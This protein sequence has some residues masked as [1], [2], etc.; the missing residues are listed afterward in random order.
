MIP[1]IIFFG[2]PNFAV[3]LLD[4]INKRQYLIDAVVT[5]SDKKSG[6]GRKLK[7]SA[8]KDYCVIKNITL[9]QPENL[10]EES[11]VSKIKKHNSDMFVVVAYRML[12]KVI[13]S[14]PRLGTFNLHA[15]LLPNY[16][17]AAPINWVIINQERIT[18][19]TTFLIDESID[20]GKILLKSE[21]RMNTNETY[22]TLH[23][24]LLK[25]AKPLIINTIN[26]LYHN[27][28]FPKKQINNF[29]LAPKLT[30]E[31][32]RVNWNDPLDK[33]VSFINGLNSY[34]GAWSQI[35]ENKIIN[36]FKIFEIEYEYTNHEYDLNKLIVVDKKITIS[37][38][39]GFLIINSLQLPNKKK[40]SDKQLLNGYSF[41]KDVFVQ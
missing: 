8:V 34:P 39:E 10:K 28:T 19:V 23:D 1:K 9:Y 12:P 13:W 38:K 37:H 35:I 2:T 20:T 40:L 5:S 17:G 21:Y 33:I 22:D 4:Q 30:K 7:S 31:N 11:F 15:S 14:I 16:R 25:I 18:G 6:R 41:K 3:Q 29:K 32:T 36:T 27:K 26:N 24:N